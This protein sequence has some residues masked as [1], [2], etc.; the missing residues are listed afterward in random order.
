MTARLHDILARF[1]LG[2]DEFY[3]YRFTIIQWLVV[4][5]TIFFLIHLFSSL[6]LNKSVQLIGGKDKTQYK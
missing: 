6:S 2:Y 4:V 1:L 5:T 3:D